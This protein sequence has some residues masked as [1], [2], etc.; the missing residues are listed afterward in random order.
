MAISH[1]KIYFMKIFRVKKNSN[2]VQLVN[3]TKDRESSFLQFNCEPKFHEWKDTEVYIYNPKVK[4]KNFY[5]LISGILVFDQTVFE[6][7][8]EIIPIQVE[9]GPKLYILNVLE[10]LNGLDYSRT[11]WDYYPRTGRKGR[12]LEHKFYENKIRNESTIFKI[13]EENKIGIFCYTDE[14][15]EDEQFYHLYHKHKL[16]GLIFKEID[17]S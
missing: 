13:P 7:A 15:D 6:K 2:H 12:I 1:I 17:N 8:G 5:G 14:R 3:L 11:K 16:T 10:C 4:P 9:R